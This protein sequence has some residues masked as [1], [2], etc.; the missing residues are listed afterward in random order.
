MFSL[1]WEAKKKPCP[2]WQGLGQYRGRVAGGEASAGQ[3][4]QLAGLAFC[5]GG[6]KR[7]LYSRR[8]TT[9]ASAVSF[10]EGDNFDPH[11]LHEYIGAYHHRVSLR[12]PAPLGAG[13]MR[14]YTTFPL[15]VI[16]HRAAL[17]GAGLPHSIA[18]S[19]DTL[20]C[21]A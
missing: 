4:A 12:K 15:V 16:C 1:G 8:V 20:G 14:L 21:I 17:D 7:I 6:A 9:R 18:T 19:V 10:C 11:A 5:Q 2:E 13:G 3:G